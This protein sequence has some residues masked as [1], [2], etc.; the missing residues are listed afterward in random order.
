MPS[1]VTRYLCSKSDQEKGRRPDET[2]YESV[3]RLRA[4]AGNSIAPLTVY[5]SHLLRR[6]CREVMGRAGD[7]LRPAFSD[8]RQ[9]KRRSSVSGRPFPSLR[10]GL[11]RRIGQRSAAPL[12]VRI[13]TD[14]P[15]MSQEPPYRTCICEWLA[16]FPQKDV[17]ERRS[18]AF[19]SVALGRLP[20]LEDGATPIAPRVRDR[21]T[22][23]IYATATCGGHDYDGTTVKF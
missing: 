4:R 19:P 1:V 16:V 12:T 22:G 8:Q 2:L 17:A 14:I 18:S 10:S 23:T 11:Y 3:P 6:S 5:F 15:V 21:K 13:R 20:S 9:R 7:A